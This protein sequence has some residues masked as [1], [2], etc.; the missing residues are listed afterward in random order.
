MKKRLFC[1]ILIAGVLTSC[2]M[3]DAKEHEKVG[4][5]KSETENVFKENNDSNDESKTD[6]QNTS[7]YSREENS[8]IR[9]EV[10]NYILNGQEDKI[11]A[12]KLKWSERF[13]DQLDVSSLY[14]QYI[15]SG[16]DINSVSDFANYIT[17]NAPIRND[18]K[19]LFITDLKTIY[20]EEVSK[21]EHL[22][23]DLYIAYVNKGGQEVPFVTVSAR[24]GY[25]HG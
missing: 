23:G 8:S 17:L 7:P 15:G 18:W 20:N 22:E 11:E 14:E 6:E 19:K 9:D 25:F 1:L 21:I 10:K 4:S 5:N 13:L 2:S 24:T 12:D 16:G 3:K